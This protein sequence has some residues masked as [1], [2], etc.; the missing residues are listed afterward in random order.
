MLTFLTTVPAIINS[1]PRVYGLLINLIS[2]TASD[3]ASARRSILNSIIRNFGFSLI[4]HWS[5]E[6]RGDGNRC[7]FG[8]AFI[9]IA[10]IFESLF[11]YFYGWPRSRSQRNEHAT[12]KL[13][14]RWISFTD[15]LTSHARIC[16]VYRLV[17]RGW[18]FPHKDL[19]AGVARARQGR[20]ARRH[21]AV[22]RVSSSLILSVARIISRTL[23]FPGDRL[24]K[25]IARIFFFFSL[26]VLF[27][28]IDCRRIRAFESEIAIP[29]TIP[30]ANCIVSGYWIATANVSESQILIS[31]LNRSI[32]C[33]VIE[34]ST[35]CENFQDMKEWRQKTF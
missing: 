31:T 21:A 16:G 27:G 4:F 19:G 11:F 33:H 26:L 24:W 18:C 2:S 34:I 13:I 10:S 8:M 15:T 20:T 30:R 22:Y 29:L 14:A 6:A 5:N 12:M 9:I 1:A 28:Y 32:K 17:L 3:S 23:K 7:V 25:G 35:D